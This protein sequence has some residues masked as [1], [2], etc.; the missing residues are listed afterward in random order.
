MKETYVATY[1]PSISDNIRRNF[2]EWSPGAIYSVAND[3][4]LLVTL[5]TTF[6]KILFVLDDG[7]FFRQLGHDTCV[8]PDFYPELE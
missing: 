1:S 6:G 4:Q 5:P 7:K 2:P 8:N 3:S